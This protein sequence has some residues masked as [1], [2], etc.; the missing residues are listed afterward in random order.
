MN[1]NI[2]IV[3]TAMVVDEQYRAG[4]AQEALLHYSFQPIFGT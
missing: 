1:A 4:K 3:N 2:I